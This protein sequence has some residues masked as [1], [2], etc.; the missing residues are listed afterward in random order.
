MTTTRKQYSPKFKARVALEALRGERT[1]NQWLRISG[2]RQIGIGED[3]AEQ[4]ADLFVTRKANA[5]T[6]T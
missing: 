3:G 6:G 2:T 5:P 4:L 1:L